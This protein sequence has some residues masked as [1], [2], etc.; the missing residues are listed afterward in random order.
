MKITIE[1]N[2]QPEWEKLIQLLKELNIGTAEIVRTKSGG[3]T[4]HLP[5][6]RGSGKE[7][8]LYVADDFTA[9]LPDFDEYS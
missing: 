2:S 4:N 5:L 9:P 7:A 8:V 1:V 6:K 3:S